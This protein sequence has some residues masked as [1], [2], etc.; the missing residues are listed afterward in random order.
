MVGD[1]WWALQ[2]KDVPMNLLAL[3]SLVT[4]VQI[5][6]IQ[7]KHVLY[8]NL[9]PSNAYPSFY[10]TLL[11][12]G[13]NRYCTVVCLIE[14]KLLGHVRSWKRGF[15]GQNNQYTVL[16]TGFSEHSL[17]KKK[18][19][20]NIKYLTATFKMAKNCEVFF[21][22]FISELLSKFV[23]VLFWFLQT[24]QM[25]W[26]TGDTLKCL[27]TSGLLHKVVFNFFLVYWVEYSFAL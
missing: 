8:I 3:L 11:Y 22:I 20:L 17:N 27:L 19:L 18:M 9:I 24:F 5:Q 10:C 15:G 13:L 12:M 21:L 25:K 14:K 26:N 23:I 1:P 16:I 2:Q 4:D 7:V 6:P